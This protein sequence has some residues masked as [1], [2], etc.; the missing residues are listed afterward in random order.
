MLFAGTSGKFP[1]MLTQLVPPFVDLNTWPWSAP[2]P[3][4]KRREKPFSTA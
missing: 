3:S 2:G 1:S 4:V